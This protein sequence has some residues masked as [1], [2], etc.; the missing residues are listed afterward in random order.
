MRPQALKE[1]IGQRA[2]RENLS[3]FIAAARERKEPLDHVLLHGPPGLGKTT[4]AHIVAR[5]LG[6][7]F[8]ATSG[9]MIAKAGDLAAILTN[10][11]AHDV[12]FID[13]I[14]RLNPAIEE[15]L[16]PAM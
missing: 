5:E 1:F 7:G 9:P 4:L 13:E 16:Y 12:L 6:V 14:H 8:R 2:V 3:V 15:V 11:E 10:L